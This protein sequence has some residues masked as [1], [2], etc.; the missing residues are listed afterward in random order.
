LSVPDPSAQPAVSRTGASGRR[1][2]T[3]ALGT[4]LA[5]AGAAALWLELG[6]GSAARDRGSPAAP[7]RQI[8]P[9]HANYAGEATCRDCHP[10]ESAAHARSG[11]ARTL[12]RVAG[13]PLVGRLDGVTVADPERTGV[14]W[15][16][17]RRGDALT[18]ERREAGAVERFVLEYA[19][20]SGHHAI[21]FVTVTARDPQ[22]PAL[23]EHRL[24][25]FAHQPLPGVT[26]GQSLAGT[27]AGNTPAGRHHGRSNTLK[28][29][30]CH[31][32]V[33]SDRGSGVLDLAVM[34]P[35]VT[36]ERCHGPAGDHVAAAR[37]GGSAG[38]LRMRR[39]PGGT[40]PADELIFCG[41]CHRLPDMI[42][43]GPTSIVP[44]NTTLVRHQPV[45]LMQSACYTRTGGGLSCS[46]CHDPHA[47]PSTD[48]AAYE[49]VCRSCHEGPKKTTCPV[50]PGAG[51]V[52]C[53][54]PRRE[55]T[56]GMRF[57]DHWIR[58]RPLGAAGT[59][60]KSAKK[61]AA[62]P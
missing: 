25:L 12:R 52:G 19:F 39:G 6:P 26:P 8:D 35:N 58:T 53:H 45:G 33:T 23:L 38:R 7:R 3:I 30:E 46:T 16:Y 49:A 40:A 27:A 18:A 37:A 31:T 60:G 4:A 34:I 51:C 43:A 20:G 41:Q 29:F 56:R 5:L 42:A 47:R 11:H 24:S 55:T 48:T 15:T 54:M 2:V 61:K 13:S 36:C 14:T 32:T 62:T 17:R 9:D 10:G 22:N 50:A 1:G 57:T 44:E 59:P 28:C 21:T